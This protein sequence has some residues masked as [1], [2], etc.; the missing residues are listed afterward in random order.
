MFF[1]RD[2][3]VY[4]AIFVIQSEYRLSTI[5]GRSF[6]VAFHSVRTEPQAQQVAP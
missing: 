1:D 6:Y 3:A 2:S 4:L 5:I